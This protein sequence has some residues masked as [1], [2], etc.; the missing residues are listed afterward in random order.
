ME[1]FLRTVKAYETFS[2]FVI[3]FFDLVILC[4]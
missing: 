1:M 3:P 2:E 4:L